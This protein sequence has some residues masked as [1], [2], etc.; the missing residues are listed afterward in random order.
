M[1]IDK[2][3]QHQK[4]KEFLCRGEEIRKKE[5][6]P[7]EGGFPFSYVSG[8][9]FNSWMSGINIFN[10]RH[11]QDHPLHKSI[12]TTYFH[13]NNNPSSYEDMMGHLQALASDEEYWGISNR[14]ETQMIRSR[15][16]ID[17]LLAEDIERCEE[18]LSNPADE[19]SGC[20]LYVEITGRYD[21]VITG[22]GDGLYQYT[23]QY[24][25]YDPEISGD[26]L[27]HNLKKLLGKMVSYQ[28]VHYPPAL[29]EEVKGVKEN[30][31][32]KVF[33][34]HGHDNEALFDMARTLEKGG[35][36]AIILR[37]QADGSK[38]II[39]KI[40]KHTDVDYAVV[41]YTPCDLGRDKDVPVEKERYRA[42]QNVVFEHGYLISKLERDHVCAFVKGDVET[43]G[44]IGGIVYV[45]MDDG[46]AW[47]VELAKNMRSAGLPVDMNK[48][49]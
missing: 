49:F 17:Q 13:R 20:N 1:A 38:T 35:F 15:K 43:P 30:M 6:H 41:L 28:A 2:A 11:L 14:E 5:F 46:G 24:H 9:L 26:T 33:I 25:F 18:F 37:E 45:S 48:F 19:V 27:I 4:V 42:R 8:P 34:V 31:S 21:S 10:D 39:E 36:E 7:A 22:F 40:E 32:N 3:V 23:P 29:K 12:H 47:K 16:T 44:D